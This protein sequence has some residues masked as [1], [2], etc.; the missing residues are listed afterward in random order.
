MVCIETTTE[1][2]LAT[3]VQLG[4]KEAS[5]YCELPSEYKP[6]LRSKIKR[7]YKVM[8]K[9]QRPRY[10]RET[11][12]NQG[13]R[14]LDALKRLQRKRTKTEELKHQREAE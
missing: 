14:R 5:D 3:I 1:E 11:Y 13:K 12:E 6:L 2:I 9:Q 10:S 7:I 4:N 8:S